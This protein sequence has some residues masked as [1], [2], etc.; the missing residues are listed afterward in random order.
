MRILL[1]SVTNRDLSVLTPHLESV[2]NLRLPPKTTME[3]AYIS[4]GLG[5]EETTLL[6]DAGARVA[7]ALPKPPNATYAV[8]EERHDWSLPTF[9][10]LA[11]EKQRLLDLASEERYDGI[12]FVDSDLV[13]GPETL[14][15]LIYSQKDVV[16]AVFWTSWE[17]ATPPLPQVW[18]RHPY[19]FSGRGVSADEFLQSLGEKSLRPVG[20]LGACT[21]IRSNVFEKVQWFPLV[22]GLP[23]HGMWQGE[24]RHFC[25]R[26]AQNHVGLWADAWPDIY[27]IYRPSD[28]RESYEFAAERVLR[29][30]VGD[31]VSA[32]LEA[33]E[34][35]ELLGRREHVRGR[36]GALEVLPEIEEALS[37]MEVGDSKI[38]K[39]YF[40]VWWKVESYRGK[41]KNVLLRLLDAKRY[42]A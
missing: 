24:D 19:E 22:E 36:L 1:A 20:G 11:R 37:E 39:L 40:P 28:I 15:S 41:R 27:H 10:W 33:V 30:S 7:A 18:M 4:D 6:L 42:T 16:S 9:G 8:R 17:P 29:P 34:E 31:W 21:L 14:E 35:K 13:L 12:F 3:L 25:V 32:V 5:A 26:A 23:S 2:K 38:V